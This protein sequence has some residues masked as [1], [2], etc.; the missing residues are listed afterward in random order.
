MAA[1]LN[2]KRFALLHLFFLSFFL[3]TSSTRDW[4]SANYRSSPPS[5]QQYLDINRE[6]KRK[7]HNK[8][9]KAAFFILFFMLVVV[10][11]IDCSLNRQW[12]D[13]KLS[14]RSTPCTIRLMRV[15]ICQRSSILSMN[16]SFFSLLNKT[17][18]MLIVRKKKKSQ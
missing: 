1:S 15:D 16:L 7:K 3:F 14:I 8:Q 17:R 18:T 12:H 5:H 13:V 11:K 4:V 6:K 10:L 9:A 2:S